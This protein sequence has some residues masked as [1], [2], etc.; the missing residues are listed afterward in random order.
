MQ[1]QEAQMW[2]ALLSMPI[3][4]KWYALKMVSVVAPLL[5]FKLLSNF[6]LPDSREAILQIIGIIKNKGNSFPERP[7]FQDFCFNES[8][9]G[10]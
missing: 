3:D 7:L 5:C 6:S 9:R 8:G 4:E 2:E 1:E 10:R